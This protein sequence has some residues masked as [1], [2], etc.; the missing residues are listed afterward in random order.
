MNIF[1]IEAKS[2]SFVPRE[3]GVIEVTHHEGSRPKV[4]DHHDH[5]I[6]SS[7]NPS[8]GSFVNDAPWVLGLPSC[9]T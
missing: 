9:T 6:G 5:H 8:C 2:T 3:I 1:V 7:T 4:S